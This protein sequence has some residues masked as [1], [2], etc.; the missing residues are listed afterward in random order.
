M[1]VSGAGKKLGAVEQLISDFLSGSSPEGER[2]ARAIMTKDGGAKVAQRSTLPPP[3]QCNAAKTLDRLQCST[4]Q[5]IPI[6]SPAAAAAAVL[7]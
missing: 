2:A 7:R 4:T 6:Q 3:M 1:D 5:C